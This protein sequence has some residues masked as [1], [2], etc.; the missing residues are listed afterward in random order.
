VAAVLALAPAARLDA[1]DPWV[2]YSEWTW[3]AGRDG[4][5]FA[6]D[7]SYGP[8]DWPRD[9]DVVLEVESDSP[10]Y[11]RAAVLDRF[12]GFRWRA[13]AAGE[14]Q[15]DLPMQL[16]GFEDT[17]RP[18]RAA[19]TDRIGVDVGSLESRYLIGAGSVLDVSGVPGA[20]PSAVGVLLAERQRLE[21]GDSY[22]VRAYSPSP[23]D[24]EMR[25]APDGYPPSLRPYATVDLPASQAI[26]SSPYRRLHVLARRLT[27]G[28]PTTFDAV[29]SIARHLR[30]NYS[31]SENPP[32]RR[33]PLAAF[34]SR[35]RLGYC[36]QFSGAM[37]LMLRTVG[38]PSRVA[39]GFS[40]GTAAEDRFLVRDLDAH[41]WVEVY[42]RGIG[43]VAF[44]PTPAA[45][46]ASS[47]LAR[48]GAPILP[49][50]SGPAREPPPAAPIPKPAAAPRG[51]GG[52]G[53][54][55]WLA[56]LLAAPLLL[57]VGAAAALA[58]R[59]RRSRLLAPEELA[60]AQL[61]EL[62]AGVRRLRRPLPPKTTLLAFE[63]RMRRSRRTAVA[64]YAARLRSV[65][66]AGRG[67]PASAGE[68]SAVRRE[69]SA[70]GGLRQ[71]LRGL[72]AFP[73]GGPLP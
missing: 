9:G 40:P 71:R 37:A 19:W 49:A 15:R 44:D 18:L 42:F 53:A 72:R 29:E 55:T 65:R 24:Q 47:R 30:E 14:P 1:A 57:V 26:E 35:D 16:E 25:N 8:I 46:P 63:E 64:T 50:G 23:T 70:N 4:E 21:E 5:T 38:I 52:G 34:L 43:W 67:G 69:L 13:A 3:T 48:P 32:R 51:A 59:A 7:H 68:R 12:D 17:S 28:A 61:R 73:P 39:A 10:H 58:L 20:R 11:W 54:P 41:S 56:P 45:A 33:Y 66:Y 22:S 27:A 36:Q 6:W 60:E 2:D 62:G 31:Y